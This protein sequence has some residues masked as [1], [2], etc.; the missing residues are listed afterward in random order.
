MD[1]LELILR[2]GIGLHLSWSRLAR[3]RGLKS[4]IKV[5]GGVGV[6]ALVSTL[7]CHPAIAR[8]ILYSHSTTVMAEYCEGAMKD[9][10]LS[11]APTQFMSFGIG[12]LELDGGGRGHQHEIEFVR[13]NLLAKRWNLEAAQSNIFLWGGAGR[14][15]ITIAPGAADNGGHNHGGPVLPGEA[16]V[17]KETASNV[18]GQI[19][20]ETRRIYTSLATDAHFAANF[21]H[22]M[23]TLQFG[24]APY[25]HEANGLAT[26][27]VVSAT[28]FSGNVQPD[29]TQVSLLLRLFKKFTWIE[30][31][32]TTDGKPQVRVMFTF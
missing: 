13:L 26:W 11:Y 29:E 23:D 5:G 28:H 20:Y 19:D 12:H 10:Q 2:V 16:A 1:S 27:L 17:F 22:R 31:G 24:I 32:A 15:T 7:A 8:P 6:C 3:F 14:S 21:N 9:I 30:A 18:G 4:T 25:K